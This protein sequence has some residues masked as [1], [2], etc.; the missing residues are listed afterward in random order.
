MP[1]EHEPPFKHGAIQLVFN[2]DRKRFSQ[3][4][5]VKKFGQTHVNEAVVVFELTAHSPPFRQIGLKQGFSEE[6]IFL[7]LRSISKSLLPRPQYVPVNRG[8]QTQTPLTQG[9]LKKIN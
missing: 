4:R 7:P 1:L 8:G 6:N 9:L 2:E 3:N 5:P